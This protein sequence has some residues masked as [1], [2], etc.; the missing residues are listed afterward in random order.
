MSSLKIST[1]GQRITRNMLNR[2]MRQSIVASSLGMVWVAVAMGIPITMYMECLGA[3]AVMI[4]MIVTV[5]QLATV[6]Q[7][8]A[9]YWIERLTSRK[10]MWALLAFVHRLLW[11][12]LAFLPF[13]LPA[14]SVWGPR[15]ALTLVTISWLLAQAATPGWF[16]WMADLI[17]DRGRGQF[18]GQRQTATMIVHLAGMGLSGWLLDLFP[19][20]RTG[21]GV[22]TGFSLVFGLAAVFGCLDIVVHYGVPEPRNAPPA[23]ALGLVKRLLSPLQKRDFRWLTLA[24]G[25]WFFT[26]GLTG[27]FGILYL[28]RTYQVT[29][30]HLSIIMISASLGTAASGML[31]GHLMDLI[32]PRAFGIIV[33]VIS[34]LL[35]GTWFFFQ[36]SRF[37]VTVP[38]LGVLQLPQPIALLIPVNFIAGAFFSGVALCQLNLLGS[39]APQKGR[40]MAMAVH[41]TVIGGIAALGP[42]CGGLITDWITLHPLTLALPGGG[43]LGFM[44]VLIIIQ[45]LVVCCL[46]VPC[47]LK[48]SRQGREFPLPLLVG[49]PLRAASIIHGLMR[50]SGAVSQRERARAVRRLGKG[51]NGVVVADLIE[52]LDDPSS[53]VR[54][55]ATQALGRI[56]TTQAVDILVQKLEDGH[57]DLAPQIARALRQVPSQ[58]SVDALVRKLSDP[59]RETRSESAR[60]LGKIGDRRASKPL[61][62]LLRTCQDDKVF[63]AASEALASLGEVEAIYQILPRMKKTRNPILKRSLTTDIGNLLGEHNGFYKLFVQEKLELGCQSG[64]ILEKLRQRLRKQSSL[65]RRMPDLLEKTTRLESAY[66]DGELQVAA[67]L[68]LELGLALAEL[69]YGIETR[70]NAPQAVIDA[71]SREDP[72]FGVGLW[73]LHMLCEQWEDANL[74][75]LDWSDIFL[76]IYFIST[77]K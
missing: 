48:I 68:L 17:P 27:S 38:M 65:A 76:G 49:N 26:L 74:G 73:Y 69:T 25:I 55:A 22:W 59:E 1:N 39:L 52:Q 12:V 33:M 40:T 64:I 77:W 47:L 60:T 2:G 63:S 50:L 3:S 8:P 41:W 4:G 58:R 51:S 61:L 6:M 15:L 44:H 5:Q 67:K 43:P 14:K 23:R 36:N 62:E 70:K 9:A 10:Q 37:S 24:F 72:H 66:E 57:S 56:G 32:G 35:G 13:L 19:D 7:I 11:V 21:G 54:E 42:I 31:W 46:G 71:L 28:T 34:P 75:P 29:Y 53:D 30:V 16:S 45:I 18:W 20:P